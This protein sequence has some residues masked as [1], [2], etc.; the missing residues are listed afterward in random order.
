MF[1]QQ[2]NK[3]ALVR[4]LPWIV[5]TCLTVFFLMACANSPSDSSSTATATST[6]TAALTKTA[7][8]T[9]T[10][11]PVH[12]GGVFKVAGIDTAVQPQSIAGKACGTAITVTY[13]ATFHIAANSPGGTI[14]FTYTVNNGRSSM[15]ASVIVK[16]DQASAIYAFSWSGNLPADHTYPG[17]GGVMVTSPNTITSPLV[18]PN[19]VCS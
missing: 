6:K 12:P 10:S 16:A 2:R 9:A 11:T 3:K 7:T 17:P 13:T 5:F 15:P 18:K 19:G 8:P 14:H 1:E 4:S